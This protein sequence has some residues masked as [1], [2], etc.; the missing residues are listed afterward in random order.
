MQVYRWVFAVI[1]LASL[2]LAALQVVASRDAGALPPTHRL[3]FK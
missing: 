1:V 2:G 3:L